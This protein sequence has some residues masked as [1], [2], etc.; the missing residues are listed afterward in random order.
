MP[1]FQL[2][3]V[4]PPAWLVK[5]LDKAARGFLW[6][7]KDV[8]SGGR[9]LVSWRRL[10]CP[11]SYGGLGIPNLAG[12]SIALRCRWLWQSWMDPGK[13]WI[14]LPLPIDDRVR[15]IFE[16]SVQF[17][18]GDGAATQFW[19]G[20]WHEG[21]KFS[22]AFPDLFKQ[23]TLRR[24]TI[25]AAME[26]GKW[27]RHLKADLS[28]ASL[29]Q[30]S[31]LWNL[32]RDVHLTPGTPDTLIW[33]WTANGMF[34]AS[35]AYAAQ[36]IG[37]IQPSFPQLIWTSDAPP[38]CKFYSW[39]AVLGRCL[40]ADNLARRG[41]PHNPLCP[42]CGAAPMTAAHLLA[43]CPFAQDIWLRIVDKAGLPATLVPPMSS[44]S[45]ADWLQTTTLQLTAEKSKTW[46]SIVP[47]VWWCLW[48][49]RNSRI[50]K[51]KASTTP[52]VFQDILSEASSWVNAGRCR[53]LSLLERPLEPD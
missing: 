28:A 48:L 42:L 8:V 35:S 45:L 29:T 15:A 18:I 47:L 7:N 20:P 6:A 9:C 51:Q 2:M 30:F 32:L 27:I 13:P 16:A 24:I 37:M 39:L 38:K 23:C 11:K 52:Q 26:N 50:F 41:W 44:T 3:T 40:T 1:I 33:K 49:E 34:S 43:T 46:R 10:C 5:K 19:T 4:H 22:V 53:V 14:G 36:F 31:A 25:R 12:Q 17:M 21:G